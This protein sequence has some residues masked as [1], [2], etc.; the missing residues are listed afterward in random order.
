LS[1]QLK[2]ISGE[3]KGDATRFKCE[4]LKQTINQAKAVI[5]SGARAGYFSLI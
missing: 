5:F 4:T 2:I 1:D 3:E